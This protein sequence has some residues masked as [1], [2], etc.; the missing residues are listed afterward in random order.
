[1]SQEEISDNMLCVFKAL[2]PSLRTD[3]ADIIPNGRHGS[4]IHWL[5][6]SIKGNIEVFGDKISYS[7]VTYT[8]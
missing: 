4:F 7:M 5:I 3:Y 1:M 8:L 6:S 2:A